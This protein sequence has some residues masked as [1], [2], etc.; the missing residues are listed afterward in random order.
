M[1]QT[2][3]MYKFNQVPSEAQIQK[4]LRKIIFGSNVYCP[5]CKSRKVKSEKNRY[6]CRKCR[7]RF[8]LISNTW[9]KHCRLPLEQLWFVLWCWTAQIPV[10]QCVS[11][12]RLSEPTI[13]KW[14]E[15]FRLNLPE[16][17]TILDHIIQL[18]E[19]Y[20]GG[21]KKPTTLFMAKQVNDTGERKLAY[22]LIHGDNPCR[23]HAWWFLQSYIKPNSI[24]FTMEQVF[25]IR[26]INGGL[27]IT[28]EIS[29]RNLSLNKP[30]R[31]RVC[32][33]SCVPL[34]EECTIMLLWTNYLQ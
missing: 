7:S 33:E 21:K 15:V 27:Y 11:L 23:E 19:A 26:L 28:V 17:E 8:S 22:Q 2:M 20:F 31:L 32:L 14:Y 1:H 9:L 10:K 30:V 6:K 5:K 24:L 4:F 18:D 29:I 12:S 16:N 34:S 25:I 3:D 13:R